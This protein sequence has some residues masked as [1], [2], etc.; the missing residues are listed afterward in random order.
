MSFAPDTQK[1][2]KHDG[3]DNCKGKKNSGYIVEVTERIQG[4][5]LVLLAYRIL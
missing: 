4:N 2:R 5:I 1:S 3:S